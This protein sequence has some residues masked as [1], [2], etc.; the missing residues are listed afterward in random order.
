MSTVKG[1]FAIKVEFL[2]S[3]ASTD[4]QSLKTISLR[5]STEYTTGKVAIVTGTAG[6]AAVSLGSF[7]NLY[8]NAAGNLVSIAT[9]LRLAFSWSGSNYRKLVDLGDTVF[10]LKSRNGSAAVTDIDG[11]VSG[12]DAS[13]ESGS[14]TGTYT[15]VLYGT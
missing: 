5:E 9:P 3:T 8:R 10:V 14:G 2:D 13:L 15:I 7:D 4:L 11:A 12:V 1:A 6:T